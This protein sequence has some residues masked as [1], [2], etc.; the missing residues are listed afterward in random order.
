MGC[1]CAGGDWL[2]VLR[3]SEQLA[4][5]A[6]AVGRG[7]GP[8]GPGTVVFVEGDGKVFLKLKSFYS[9]VASF[10]KIKT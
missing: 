8:L 5:F 10:P 2:N 4:Q 6:A 7:R 3:S 1:C 9:E